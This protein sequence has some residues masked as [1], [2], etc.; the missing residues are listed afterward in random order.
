[1]ELLTEEIR[2]KIRNLKLLKAELSIIKNNSLET[3]YFFKF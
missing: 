1:M 3:L 2:N